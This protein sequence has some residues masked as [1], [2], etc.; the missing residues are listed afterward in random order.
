MLID[1]HAHLNMTQFSEDLEEVMGRARASGVGEVLNVG[2]DAASFEETL[3][4]TERYEEIYA[5]VGIHPH[6]AK[7]WSSDVE[8]RLKDFLLR[9]SVRAVGE[10]GLDYYRDLSKRDVQKDVFRRQ[11]GLAL[12]FKKPIVVHCRDA[13]R[14]VIDILHEEGATEV[15]GIF[16]AFSGGLDEAKEVLKMGFLIGIG[17]PLT[18]KNSRL[19]D[20]ISRLPSSA[21]VLETD[22]PYLTPVPHRGKRN[23]PSY[24][25]LICKKTAEVMGVA[26]EDVERAAETNYRRMMHGDEYFPPRIAYGLKNNIYI[27]VTD[28]CSNNCSF[29]SRLRYNNFLYGYNLNMLLDP[30]VEEMV[31]AARKVSADFREGE[32]VFCGYGEPTGRLGEML[33]VAG[34]LKDIGRPIRLTTNGQGSLI[35]KRNIVPELESLFDRVSV[36]LNAPDEETYLRLCQPIAGGNA[37]DSVLDFIRKAAGSR[38]ECK[39]TALDYP[40]VDLDSCRKLVESIPG[41]TFN[42]RRYRLN[43]DVA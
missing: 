15:K 5:A 35:N 39:V 3:E 14:D 19:P 10:I 6:N 42:V 25:A 2:Y 36:S 40:E 31:T 4:L 34:E 24:V 8:K 32:I 1:S 37:F 29:C 11:I 26:I 22:C 41:A 17:G 33:A 16:H 38:M 43:V 28:S 20:V 18:Y 30:T 27:N 21:I 9:K 13:F 7:D 12:Y 23:E